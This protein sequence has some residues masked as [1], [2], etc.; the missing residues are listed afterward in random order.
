M[1]DGIAERLLKEIEAKAHRVLSVKV[2]AT[3][4][5]GG[6]CREAREITDKYIADKIIEFIK[7]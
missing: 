7:K 3:P 6:K 5:I 4:H 2:I 1:F